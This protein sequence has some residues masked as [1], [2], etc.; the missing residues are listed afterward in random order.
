MSKALV[1][2][3]LSFSAFAENHMLFLGGGSEP[4]DK[5][6]TIFDNE[7]KTVGSFLERNKK[8]WRAQVSFNGGHSKTEQYLREGVEKV[9]GPNRPF[10]E[11]NFA[12][13][14]EEYERKIID[15]Q[16]KRGDQLLVYITTHGAQ[17]TDKEQTH[18]IG[19]TGKGASD[20]NTLE[21][22]DLVSMDRLQDLIK[23]AELLGV[24]LAI[25]DFSCHSG[26]SLALRNPNTCVITASGPNHFGYAS[27]G[28]R[29]ARNMVKGKNLE[30]VYLETFVDRYEVAFP[31]IST[32]TGVALQDR[33]YEMLTPYLHY[34]KAEGS[35]KLSGY[36]EK[37]VEQNKCEEADARF[38]EL[39][40]LLTQMEGIFKKNKN[41]FRDLKK[42]IAEYH[43]LQKKMKDDLKKFDLVSMRTKKEKI[44]VDL[45]V[46]EN[47]V[48]TKSCTEYTV[49]NLLNLDF[50][51]MKKYYREKAEKDPKEAVWSAAGIRKMEKAEELKNQLLAG[52][53]VYQQYQ[54]YYKSIPDL[55]NKSWNMALKVSSELQKIYP[56]MYKELEK[57]NP[58]P[59]PCKDFVI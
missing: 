11:N 32:N 34:W 1:L 9:A 57:S 29:F 54:N 52:N 48:S 5:E 35:Q 43:N 55:E 59:N 8:T 19:M 4:Q 2:L 40:G 7:V 30:S 42:A 24:K 45:T 44:C 33:F 56:V 47:S 3:L 26:A 10:T 46:G 21:G 38:E 12:A 53:P 13:L 36:L 41:D 39:T 14:I 18:K 15:G 58:A 51:A 49:E 28:D 16:L 31:M 50:E 25:M 22:A 27:W 6:T 17:K 37:E 20:L 23:K